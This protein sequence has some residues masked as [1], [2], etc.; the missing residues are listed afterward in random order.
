MKKR[1]FSFL[2]SL[3]MVLSVM[4]LSAFAL[5]TAETVD[6]TI[7]EQSGKTQVK[8]G[9]TLTYTV[10]IG[11]V[12]NLAALQF[13]LVIPSQL[14]FVSASESVPQAEQKEWDSDAKHLKAYGMQYSSSAFTKL[15]TVTCRAVSGGSAKLSVQ[16]DIFVCYEDFND[17]STQKLLKASVNSTTVGIGSTSTYV[18]EEEVDEGENEDKDNKDNSTT[19]QISGDKT[20]VKT[21]A[22]VSGS[23]AT[24]DAPTSAQLNKIVDDPNKNG[25]VVLDLSKLDDSVEKVNLPMSLIKKVAEEAKKPNSDLTSL[26]VKLPSGSVV[27]DA[28]ILQTI[29]AEA[30]GNHIRLVLDEVG[31]KQLNNAQKAAISTMDVYGGYEAYLYCVKSNRRISDFN[32]GVATLS[33]PFK[34]PAGK[35][36]NDFSVWYVSDNGKM[37]RLSTWYANKRL[38]WDVSH[39]SDFVIVYDK[40]SGE[41]ANPETGAVI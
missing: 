5:G 10:T 13:T 25:S 21:E 20:T 14:E 15:L 9:D 30:E 37:E 8:V 6:L 33:V 17:T 40:N 41:K 4:P 27:L 31:T 28:K 24:I 39:F 22:S 2:L 3:L 7:S 35:S 32:G 26:E 18:P 29:V 12:T 23:T 11:E 19:I 1:W 16:D 36:A 38:Y 34:V